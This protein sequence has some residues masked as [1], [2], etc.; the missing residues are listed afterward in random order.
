MPIFLWLYLV[1]ACLGFDCTFTY[2]E[3]SVMSKVVDLRPNQI[4]TASKTS[5]IGPRWMIQGTNCTPRRHTKRRV[6]E[7]GNHGGQ[8]P[9]QPNCGD[10]HGPWWLPQSGH[11]GCHGQPMVVGTFV[12]AGF[13]T[14]VSIPFRP[15]VF[16]RDFSSICAAIFPLKEDK[17]G[18]K[19]G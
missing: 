7:V 13:S 1:S 19:R 2:I 10:R 15:F 12:A 5:P 17:L 9:P 3:P 8:R 6:R 11:G 14:G 16:P 4:K 18:C